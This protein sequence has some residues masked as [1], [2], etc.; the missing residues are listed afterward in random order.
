[1]ACEK[2]SIAIWHHFDDRDEG[3]HEDGMVMMMMTRMPVT[4]RTS[5]SRGWNWVSWRA[6]DG[7]CNG[8][9]DGR[10]TVMCRKHE[11]TLLV[12]MTQPTNED[13]YNTRWLHCWWCWQE[14][15]EGDE[16][17]WDHGRDGGDGD[18]DHDQ[19]S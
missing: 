6:I 17:N 3:K 16:D 19:N 11:N 12:A 13:D 7:D 18:A 1:M 10:A 5:L 2:V 8:G 14:E 15:H 9:L 4:K